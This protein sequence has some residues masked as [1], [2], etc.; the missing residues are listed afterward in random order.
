MGIEFLQQMPKK[1]K[2]S[3]SKNIGKNEQTF[4]DDPVL[5]RMMAFS[6]AMANELWVAKCQIERLEALLI[7]HGVISKDEIESSPS[8]EERSNRQ[9]ALS[10]FSS[11][12]MDALK[13]RSASRSPDE[14]TLNKFK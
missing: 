1:I 2:V 3:T 11:V 14:E 8:E 7:K 12:L 13:G 9:E 10:N 5:D 4:F 6:M